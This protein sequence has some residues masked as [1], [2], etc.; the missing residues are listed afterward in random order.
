VTGRHQTL[1]QRRAKHAHDELQR[2][3][4][5]PVPGRRHDQD[6][7][8]YGVH[9][10]RLPIR[11]I[12]SGLGQALAF[13]HAKDYC[14]QLL[15]SLADWV[16]YERDGEPRP[17]RVEPDALLLAILNGTSEQ[18]Q[19]Y[20]AEVLAYLRWLTRFVEAKNL[21]ADDEE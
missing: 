15:V 14:P 13:L 17:A 19:L 5:N 11:I 7:K 18:L 12:A 6:R 1:D 9:V 2:F 21:A 20:T 16:L 10:R 3:L 4:A 8:K